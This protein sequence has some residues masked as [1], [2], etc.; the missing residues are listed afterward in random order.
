M[1]WVKGARNAAGLFMVTDHQG[2][3]V[4]VPDPDLVPLAAHILADD[5]VK[6]LDPRL[7]DAVFEM[8]RRLRAKKGKK[9]EEQEGDLK[10]LDRLQEILGKLVM[11]YLEGEK[12][13]PGVP[14]PP[15]PSR[16]LAKA[17]EG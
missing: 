1:A 7:Q 15:A 16:V 8:R 17:K 12:E 3:Q 4:W 5:K 2:S 14:R 6:Y 9:T 11:E 10:L 13:T